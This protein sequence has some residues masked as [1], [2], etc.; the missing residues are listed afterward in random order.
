ML[1]VFGRASAAAKIGGTLMDGL[2]SGFSKTAFEALK[3]LPLAA[4]VADGLLGM[5]A[6]MGGAAASGTGCLAA[7]GPIVPV[8][9][10][11]TAV[12]GLGVAIWEL[13]GKKALESLDRT[14][15]WGTDIGLELDRSLL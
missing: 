6:A 15:R 1:G 5:G 13:W 8:V 11:V 2:Q 12:V 14:L 7:L 4:L 3:V 10:G 9:L